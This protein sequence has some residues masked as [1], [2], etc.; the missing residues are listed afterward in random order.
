M[1]GMILPRN[2]AEML[3]NCE[4]NSCIP[5]LYG[6]NEDEGMGLHTNTVTEYKQAL[7]QFGTYT[8]QIFDC[9]PAAA[10]EKAKV[11]AAQIASDHW[12]AR[13]C[14]FDLASQKRNFPAGT[15]I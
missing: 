2:T 12:F 15:I 9:Y 8:G 1:V 14:F 5:M 7:K 6:S 11:M 3:I 10:D 13:L 4:R